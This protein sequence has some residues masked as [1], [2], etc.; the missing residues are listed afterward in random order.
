MR[1]AL[2]HP[3]RHH[4]ARTKG[5][6][7]EK[8]GGEAVREEIRNRLSKGFRLLQRNCDFLLLDR[9]VTCSLHHKK[10]VVPLELGLDNEERDDHRPSS[11]TT[12]SF[13]DQLCHHKIV[14]QTRL[15]HLVHFGK[16]VQK[17]SISKRKSTDGIPLGHWLGDLVEMWDIEY[18]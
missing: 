1:P 17:E 3:L 5:S 2:V 10:Q 18:P 6:E 15:V 8:E 13:V 9:S 16:F 12:S 14:H 4:E 11:T 7:K